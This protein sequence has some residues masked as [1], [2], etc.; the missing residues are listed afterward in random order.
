MTEKSDTYNQFV[1]SS[2]SRV[3]A[4]R[5][6]DSKIKLYW[7]QPFWLLEIFQLK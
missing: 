7:R 3:V 5:E 6:K 4:S 2:V 1:N